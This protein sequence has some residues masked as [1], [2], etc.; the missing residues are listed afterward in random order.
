[1]S[2]KR[3]RLCAMFLFYYVAM[4]LPVAPNARAADNVVYVDVIG[5]DW[6]DA[7]IKAYFEAFEKETGI[8]P[9][10]VRLY[11]GKTQSDTESGNVDVDVGHSAWNDYLIGVKNGCWRQ[12]II[13]EVQSGRN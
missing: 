9:I 13:L 10:P 5:G 12:L 6:A 1:M 2:W 7:T 3:I 8:K 11:Q 4:L